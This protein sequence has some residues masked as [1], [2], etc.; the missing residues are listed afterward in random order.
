[1][2]ELVWDTLQFLDFDSEVFDVPKN[3]DTILSHSES[4]GDITLNFCTFHKVKFEVYL[5][6]E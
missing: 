5:R 1:M 4:K 3:L 2:V 6:S